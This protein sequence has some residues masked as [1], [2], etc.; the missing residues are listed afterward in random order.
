MDHIDCELVVLTWPLGTSTR[1]VE[2]E[3]QTVVADWDLGAL[4]PGEGSGQAQLL[5]PRRPYRQ[6]AEKVIDEL[7]SQ[8]ELLQDALLDGQRD[9]KV[10]PTLSAALP[11]QLSS[12][13]AKHGLAGA[14]ELRMDNLEAL[15]EKLEG[16]DETAHRQMLCDW[17]E[18]FVAPGLACPL[19]SERL[20]YAP[21]CPD[22]EFALQM[23]REELE[24]LALSELSL[25]AALRVHYG[26]RSEFPDQPRPDFGG[27]LEEIDELLD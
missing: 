15:L 16:L 22:P 19:R 1:V 4:L 17:Y 13:C 18:T 9:I 10:R 7:A 27:L 23:W 3:S 11:D 6:R 2:P 8:Q 5:D 24:E 14:E 21:V 12:F 20:L 25:W 26:W